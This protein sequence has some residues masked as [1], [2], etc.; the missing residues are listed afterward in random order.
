[1]VRTRTPVASKMALAM[2]AQMGQTACLPT[3][4]TASSARDSYSRA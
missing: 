4:A 2:A 3:P 1:M